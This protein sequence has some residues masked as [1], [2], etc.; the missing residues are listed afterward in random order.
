MGFESIF[1]KCHRLGELYNDS[2]L[3]EN[4]Y[5]VLTFEN[6]SCFKVLVC[7]LKDVLKNDYEQVTKNVLP[8]QK[9]FVHFL[10]PLI[11]LSY[12]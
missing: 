5:K 12:H 9:S 1:E 10:F 8:A 3:Y 4:V 6:I 11:L 2:R 7:F